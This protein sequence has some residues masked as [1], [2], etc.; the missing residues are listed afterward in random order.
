MHPFIEIV[1]SG[2]D[3]KLR[4]VKP[5]DEPVLMQVHSD[6]TDDHRFGEQWVVVTDQ[7]VLLV[8]AYGDNGTVD[9]PIAEV[10]DVQVA[11]VILGA[12]AL[13]TT[14]AGVVWLPSMRKM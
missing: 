3:D 6:M 10:A 13:V 2:I 12:A 11:V 5:K 8:P 4:R 14:V 9:I 1:P 7:R